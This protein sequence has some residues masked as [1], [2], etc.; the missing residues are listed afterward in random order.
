[1][2]GHLNNKSPP[3]NIVKSFAK[4][5]WHLYSYSDFIQTPAGVGKYGVLIWSLCDGDQ[6]GDSIGSTLAS[7]LRPTLL[8]RNMIQFWRWDWDEKLLRMYY[9][10]TLSNTFSKTAY[11]TN[12][13]CLT[14]CAAW[15]DKYRNNYQLKPAQNSEYLHCK[16]EAFHFVLNLRQSKQITDY[17]TQV[18]LRLSKLVP[19]QLAAST[20]HR[21]ISTVQLHQKCRNKLF[22][23]FINMRTADHH[24][25]QRNLLPVTLNIAIALHCKFYSAADDPVV[26]QSDLLL[27]ERAY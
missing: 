11:Y 13:W 25:G 4:I 9:F 2:H 27:V 26:S 10:I 23:T 22:I 3:P 6:V 17:Y 20:P 14:Q 21:N 8:T 16:M 5:G 18:L 7:H 15:A 19:L 12:T 24:R 1:M